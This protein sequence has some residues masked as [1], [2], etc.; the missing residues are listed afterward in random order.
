MSALKIDMDSVGTPIIIGIVRKYYSRNGIYDLDDLIQIGYIGLIKAYNTYRDDKGAKFSTYAS[1]C[2]RN[3]ILC[4]LRKEMCYR[5]HIACS[6]DDDVGFGYDDNFSLQ[7]KLYNESD[8]VD[9]VTDIKIEQKELWSAIKELHEDEMRMIVLYY[10]FEKKQTDIAKILGT[11]QS[12][13]SRTIKSGLR[14]LR[15]LLNDNFERG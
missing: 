6:L 2:I 14:H 10:F 13:V 8:C 11:N 3:E 4:A 12:N 15:Q 1:Y 9:W 5:G 7:D